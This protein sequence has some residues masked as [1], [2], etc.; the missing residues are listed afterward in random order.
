MC[1][2]VGTRRRPF[3]NASGVIHAGPGPAP[4]RFATLPSMPEVREGTIR[5]AGGVELHHRAWTP[6]G[7]RAGWRGSVVVVHGMGE[8]GGRYDAVASGFVGRGYAVHAMDHRGH[9]RS[10]GRRGHVERFA[11]FVA[12]VET[13]RLHV[14][15]T[16]GGPR[17]LLGHSMGGAV[18]L[19]HALARPGAWDALVLSAPAT[20]LPEPPPR[21][22][23]LVGRAASRLVPTLRLVSLDAAG[24]SRDSQVVERYR[25]D[26]LVH[27]GRYTARFGAELLDRVTSLHAEVAALTVPVLVVHG[28][29]D[30]LVPV[31]ASRA[32]IDA[33]GSAD[34]ALLEHEGLHHEVFNEPEGP[35]VL[36][37]VLD[38]VDARV[39]P[40]ASTPGS[41]TP[42]G[43]G[44]T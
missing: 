36:A 20:G 18:A 19:A 13:F 28:T 42:E 41:P 26:P 9:G 2:G 24:V 34:K 40:A 17:V 5:G 23:V 16:A 38:W 3:G 32:L 1:G 14:A 29:D 15:A 8:H 30:V 33:I 37:G 31:E 25:D 6:P 39:A 44:A 11:T 4:P 22:L 7:D 21:A 12:D 35:E 27:H 10:G 43:A